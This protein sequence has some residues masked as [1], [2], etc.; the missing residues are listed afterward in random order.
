[1]W[2]YFLILN[3]LGVKRL[4]IIIYL[5]LF[6]G[7]KDFYLHRHYIRRL[8]ILSP[9]SIG[10]PQFRHNEFIIIHSYLKVSQNYQSLGIEQKHFLFL[11]SQ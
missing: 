10:T 1:M 6:F 7:F 2:M 11:I 8:S 5:N 4:I 9:I 3:N